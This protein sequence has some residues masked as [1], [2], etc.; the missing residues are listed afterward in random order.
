MSDRIDE[1]ARVRAVKATKKPTPWWKNAIGGIILG[2]ILA[3]AI[4]LVGALCA[5][6]W[7][8]FL[9]GWGWV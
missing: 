8:L 2:L 3:L 9:I 5:T 6:T 1:A 4:I 7:Y